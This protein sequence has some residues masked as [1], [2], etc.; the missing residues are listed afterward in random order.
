MWLG[1]LF[2]AQEDQAEGPVGAGILLSQALLYTVP[3]PQPPRKGHLCLIHS[4]A[5]YRP[6]EALIIRVSAYL[7]SL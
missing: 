4:K 3:T 5:P 6:A 2:P 7:L 1:R